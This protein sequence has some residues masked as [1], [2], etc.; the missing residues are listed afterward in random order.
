MSSSTTHPARAELMKTLEQLYREHEGKISDRWSLYLA[1]YDRLFAPLR[2]RPVRLLEIGIQ[3]GGSLEIWSKFFLH[4]EKIVG[5][6]INPNCARL[7]YDDPRICLVVANA[8][9]DQAQQK[10]LSNFPCFDLII[11]DGSHQS[12]DIVRSFARYFP[13]LEHGGLYVVEDLHCSYWKEYGGGLFHPDSSMTFLKR[14][15]DILNHQ[16]WGIDMA[17]SEFMHSF[18]QRYG[19][20]FYEGL[21]REIHSV[22]FL[23]S[24]CVVKKL[25]CHENALGTRFIAGTSGIV[26][27]DLGPLHGTLSTALDQRRNEWAVRVAPIEEELLR[28]EVGRLQ[29]ELASRDTEIQRLNSQVVIRDTQITAELDGLCQQLE[30]ERARGVTEVQGLHQQLETQRA[31]SVTEVQGLHQQLE[32]QRASAEAKLAALTRELERQ[33]AECA[34]LER[35]NERAEQACAFVRQQLEAERNRAATELGGLREQLAECHLQLADYQERA[36][37]REQEVALLHSSNSWR[38]TAPLRAISRAIRPR[39]SW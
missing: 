34:V 38:V 10:I 24:M 27:S 7:Q 36:R 1:E 6:D 11:D 17:R 18:E 26:Q 30:A 19:T 14:L 3:N 5:C 28:A 21:L 39:Q 9:T 12:A 2:E 13:Y 29:G 31:R 25:E 37:Q 15:A 23:N 20:D 8:N 32:T 4:A 35:T 33:R 16:H 22:E